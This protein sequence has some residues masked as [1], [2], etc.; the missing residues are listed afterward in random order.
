MSIQNT[1]NIGDL[2]IVILIYSGNI[3]AVGEIESN[4][5]IVRKVFGEL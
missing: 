5:I 2:D 3:Y 4:M 1:T